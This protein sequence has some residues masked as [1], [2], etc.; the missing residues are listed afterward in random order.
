M[1]RSFNE[2]WN[3]IPSDLKEETPEGGEGNKQ[4]LNQLNHTLLH[5]DLAG[6]HEAKPSHEELRNWLQS[7]QVDAVRVK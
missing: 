5:L 7:G 2:W 1:T 3:A 4:S 6:R